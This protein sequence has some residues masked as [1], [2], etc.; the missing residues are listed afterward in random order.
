MIEH[1]ALPPIPLPDEAATVRL[2]QHLARLLRPGDVLLLT[3]DL[4]A[5]KT[6]LA[7]S[8]IQTLSGAAVEVPSPTFTLVQTYDTDRAPV[9]HFDLY[10]LDDPDEVEEL[11]WDEVRDDGIALVEWPDRLGP[12]TPKDRLHIAL[13]VTA[14]GA[15]RSAQL[16]GHG[17]WAA[18]LAAFT[19]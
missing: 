13:S 11:G 19:A 6:A 17:G 14:E 16:V 5:G 12:L 1:T 10:R 2:G 4:G 15:G 9:W 7:R 3:G 18:R 8:I